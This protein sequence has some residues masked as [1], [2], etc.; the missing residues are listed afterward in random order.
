MVWQNSVPL[1]RF[2]HLL[3]KNFTGMGN[4]APLYSVLFDVEL[5]RD[6]AC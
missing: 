4:S 6:V 5:F 3:W 1:E 2:V